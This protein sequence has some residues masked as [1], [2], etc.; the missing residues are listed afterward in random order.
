MLPVVIGFGAVVGVI[1]VVRALQK[2]GDSVPAPE[3][4]PP[5]ETVISDA[6]LPGGV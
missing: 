5:P 6:G 2:R 1:L 4:P 3:N